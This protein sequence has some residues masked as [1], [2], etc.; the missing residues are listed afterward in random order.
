M[1]RTKDQRYWKRG[2]ARRLG[3]R[4]LQNLKRSFE[5]G[6][7]EQPWSNCDHGRFV[8]DLADL[9]WRC[10]EGPSIVEARGNGTRRSLEAQSDIWRPTP[11]VGYGEGKWSLD[12][13]A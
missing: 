11:L 5:P 10:G 1:G 3:S 8:G 12:V 7:S 4:C 2:G 6:W 13:T 9:L